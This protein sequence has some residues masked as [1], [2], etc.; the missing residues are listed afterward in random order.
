MDK[1]DAEE[2]LGPAIVSERSV[3]RKTN[4]FAYLHIY[5]DA[6]LKRHVAGRTLRSV[7]KSW[8]IIS[9]AVG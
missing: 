6:E 3:C 4:N 5:R 8:R 2:I 7:L 9:D 1:L